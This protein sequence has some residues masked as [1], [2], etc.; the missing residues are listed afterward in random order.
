MPRVPNLHP[1]DAIPTIGY[2]WAGTP[3]LPACR[4][5]GGGLVRTFL[6]QLIH[7]GANCAAHVRAWI[8]EAG[9]CKVHGES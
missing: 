9:L 7:P 1:S 4:S 2:R 8:D 6:A 3:A 5:I